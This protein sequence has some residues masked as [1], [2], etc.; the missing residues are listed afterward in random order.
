M[1][2]FFCLVFSAGLII[3]SPNLYAQWSTDPTNN[4]IVGYGLLPE[5]ASDGAGGCYITYEQNTTY[6]RHLILE[7][8]NRYGYKPWG[9]GKQIL[10][11]FPE[12]SFAKITE[13]GRNGVIVSYMDV[14]VT[15]TPNSPVVKSRLRVQRVDSIGSFLWGLDGVRVTLSET[16]QANQA[17]VTD[18]KGGCVVAWMEGSSVFAQRIDSLGARAWGDSGTIVA[19]D[20][21]GSQLMVTDLVG[22][23]ILTWK[24]QQFQRIGRF[25]QKVWSDTGITIRG[26]AAELRIGTDNAARILGTNYLGVRNGQLL[27]TVRLQTIDTSGTI[28]WDSAGVIIDTANTNNFP[29]MSFAIQAGYSTIAWPQYIG[30]V[31]D[32]RTQIVGNDGSAVFSYGGRAIS[33]VLSNKGI[34][35]VVASDSATSLYVWFD[36]RGARGTYAQRLDT[37]GR[38]LWDTLDVLI[39]VPELSY[40]QVV[41]DGEGGFITVGTREN[42]TIRAQQVSVHGNL[43]EVL[44]AVGYYP[45]TDL[46]QGFLLYQNYP[47]PFNGW[48]N[49]LY[50]IPVSSWVEID[51]YNI[52]GQRVNTL[53]NQFRTPGTYSI[54]FEGGDLPSGIYFYVLSAARTTLHRQLVITK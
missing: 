29:P 45:V 38:Q 44:T 42:F 37:M 10:G 41:T 54:H 34:V 48:T 24:Y 14:E 39:S 30:G 46:P 35:G 28:L 31:W 47:N 36:Q 27:F 17:I 20:G 19:N 33:R 6:P 49:I 32:L 1:I 15:G 13:D 53:V 23:M 52:L 12:Q 40:E 5:L 7:R 21:S 16:D 43:G 11:L 9:S 2:R 4:L 3:C 8:L 50:E 22:G 18:A 26:G 25:G 51:V